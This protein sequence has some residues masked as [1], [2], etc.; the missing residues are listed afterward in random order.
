MMGKLQI[1]N[2]ESAICNLQSR[3]T[4][5]SVIIVLL[6]AGAL[7]FWRLDAIP[8]GWR[9]DEL[10]ELNIDTRIAA[11]WRPLYIEEAEGHEPLYH[12][13]HA[14][15]VG[16]FGSSRIGYRWLSAASGWVAVALTM[17][18]SRRLWGRWVALAAGAMMAV[19]FWPLMYSRFGLRHVGVLPPLLVAFYALW[20]GIETRSA[21]YA[22]RIP[23]FVFR[24]GWFTLAGLALAAGLYTYFAGRIVLL[25][26]AV[27]T[28]YLLFFHRRAFKTVWWG[29]LWTGVLAVLLFTPLG[30]YLA[31]RPLEA[32]LVVVGQPLIELVHGNL[33][34][35]LETT[36]GTLGMF[37]HTGDPEWLYNIA[38]RPV[39]NLPGG[40]LLW[41]GVVL[42]LYRW[43]EPRYFFLALWL[44]VGLSP[45]F[46]SI[47]AASL[48][49]TIVAQPAAYI[50]LVLPIADALARFTPYVSRI[51]H[52]ASRIRY[53]GLGI[54]YWVLGIL[55]VVN[56]FRDLRDYFVVW[57]SNGMVRF[58][59]HADVADLARALRT[60]PDVQEVAVA[61]I[62][63]ALRLDAAGL[64]VDLDGADVRP[65]LFDP[66][67][68]LVIPAGDPA[69]VALTTYPPPHPL[70][71]SLVQKWLPVAEGP[72]TGHGPAFRLYRVAGALP[73]WN[74]C[75]PTDVGDGLTLVDCRVAP[76]DARPGQR[77][78][79]TTLWRVKASEGFFPTLKFFF[80]L[81]APD[82]QLVA[83]GDRM[84]AWTPSLRAGDVLIQ[85]THLDVPA[86][87]PTGDYIVQAGVYDEDT[88]Q[89]WEGVVRLAIITLS[90]DKGQAP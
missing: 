47:P 10:I 88:G 23:Y 27:F 76:Q 89:R 18:L 20:Q 29:F 40:L 49:H 59:Y 37:T 75:A 68:A 55:L 66:A 78:E 33:R 22:I 63:E 14:V 44:V 70:V 13:I 43:R 12:Y 25:I 82:G 30:W 1:A 16:L 28:A 51:T 67:F 74:G 34:P 73:E 32:R 69:H 80:H 48:G 21:Q 81:L 83:T 39:F 19:G 77:I 50:L 72:P 17:A 52:H 26:V 46:I 42:C 90:F 11:G 57:P 85:I 31:H 4:Y 79:V 60:R 64:A 24:F 58:L 9:D 38:N 15:T 62:T 2:C 87:A 54:G 41:A 61:T 7:R 56:G 65:R 6:L 3:I 71:A 8:P 86:D 5:W 53:W 45:A 35:A 36:L 84:S